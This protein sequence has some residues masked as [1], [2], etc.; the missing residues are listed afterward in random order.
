MPPPPLNAASTDASAVLSTGWVVAAQQPFPCPLTS[1]QSSWSWQILQERG[2][3]GR[4][5]GPAQPHQLSGQQPGD[6]REGG[7]GGQG[8]AAPGPGGHAR[9]QQGPRWGIIAV[10]SYFWGGSAASLGQ[11]LHLTGTKVGPCWPYFHLCCRWD[12][13][14]RLG[15]VSLSLAHAQAILMFEAGAVQVGLARTWQ[16]PVSGVR[17][18]PP[19]STA[20]AFP[21][22]GCNALLAGSPS[23]AAMHCAP[24]WSRRGNLG[25]TPT[26]TP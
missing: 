23:W 4:H 6:A 5:G 21:L 12:L 25:P 10:L 2:G 9:I 22:M 26:P 15:V 17:A 3:G 8:W 7:A 14:S 1:V 24:E 16:G 13:L 19:L 20:L 11:C 18:A